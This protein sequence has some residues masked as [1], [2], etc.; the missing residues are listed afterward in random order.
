MTNLTT[1]QL[2]DLLSIA[3]QKARSHM[4]EG[5]AHVHF[6]ELLEAAARFSEAHYRGCE[7]GMFEAADAILSRAD[8][9]AAEVE[10]PDAP[11]AG[12]AEE[13]RVFQSARAL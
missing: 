1:I 8:E 12:W 3:A 10:E 6:Q 4:G 9:F 11:D 5:R 13:S 7:M 2:H